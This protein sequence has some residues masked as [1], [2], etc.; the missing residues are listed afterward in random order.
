MHDI[1]EFA[2]AAVSVGAMRRSVDTTVGWRALAAVILAVSVLWAGLGAW[3][4]DSSSQPLG[5]VARKTRQER[6]SAAHVPAK[7]PASEGD[8]GPDSGAVWRLRLC[9]L[10]PC[11]ELSV[12][13]PKSPKWS[14]STQV[15]WAVL[16]PVTGHEED[17]S[18]AIR[19]YA[20]DST[21]LKFTVDTFKRAFLQGRFARTDY[22]GQSARLTRD[23]H[24]PL[25]WS[26]GTITHFT[27]TTDALKYRGLSVVAAS[28]YG[29]YGFACVFREEDSAAGT[30]ICDAIIKSA[31]Y[32]E[33]QPSYIH[34]VYPQTQDPEPYDPQSDDPP[35]E[36]PLR[37]GRANS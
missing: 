36:D 5:D 9:T 18:R 12:T 34:P 11:Y 25:D 20:A 21:D 32:Q 2:A 3:A 14:R 8:D 7:Q 26:T 13:L 19:V 35:E 37:G 24:V 15:P 16:I 6:A 10:T 30:S 29:N 27:I 33:L 23:E 22:F 4:Q 28:P 1:G 31:H 17:A